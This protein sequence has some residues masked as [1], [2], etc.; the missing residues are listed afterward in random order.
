MVTKETTDQV[1][2]MA[3]CYS[4]AKRFP[5]PHTWLALLEPV[6]TLDIEKLNP[7]HYWLW[8]EIWKAAQLADKETSDEQAL[9]SP[10]KAIAGPSTAKCPS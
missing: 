4:L 8:M 2:W 7:F 6:E 3:D 5:N 1:L 10:K 9:A